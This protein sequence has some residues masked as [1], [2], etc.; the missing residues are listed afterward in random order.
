MEMEKDRAAV[1]ELKIKE[2][3]RTVIPSLASEEYALLEQSIIVDGCRN[4]IL[5]WNGFIIDGHN[6]YAICQKH[7]LNY[8]TEEIDF[9]TEQDAVV[10]II[11]NQL[12][13]RNVTDYQKG[14]LFSRK[15]T[16]CLTRERNNRVDGLTFCPSWTK[17]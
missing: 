12:G 6:R 15:R 3:F 10:W 17:S 4:A 1:K 5:T 11:N 8:D 16:S 13:R 7:R 2:S 14:E 9:D